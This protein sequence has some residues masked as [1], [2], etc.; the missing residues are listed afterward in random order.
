M[1]FNIFL[2]TLCGFLWRG[3]TD[4]CDVILRY[5]IFRIL[6]LMMFW[7]NNLA[8]LAN[9][10]LRIFFFGTKYYVVYLALNLLCSW[11][12]AG[13][14][15]VH[16]QMSFVH[17]W[18]CDPGL[19]IG[20]TSALPDRCTPPR[21]CFL[22]HVL[23]TDFIVTWVW[24]LAGRVLQSVFPMVLYKCFLVWIWIILCKKVI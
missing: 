16:R 5:Q 21:E 23:Y 7:Y 14:T 4:F 24:Y 3:L 6:F 17:C 11:P 13:I 22:N 1:S 12:S 8:S 15:G 10:K 2:K 9:K 19:C 20:Q 18:G